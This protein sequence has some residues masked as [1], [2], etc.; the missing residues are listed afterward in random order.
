MAEITR[1]ANAANAHVGGAQ[2]TEDVPGSVRAAVVDDDELEVVLA[3]GDT[4]DFAQVR[5]QDAEIAFL[6]VRWYYD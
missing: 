1:Q 5:V 4:H 2:R 3:G 6:V